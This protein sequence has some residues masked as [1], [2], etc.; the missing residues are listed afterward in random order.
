MNAVVYAGPHQMELRTVPEPVLGVGEVLVRVTATGICGSDISGFLGHSARRKPG[1]ILGHEVVG[2]LLD[3]TRV[4]VNPLITC[5]QCRACRGGRQNCCPN[6]GLL[7]LDLRHGGYADF[8]AVPARNVRPLKA[9][10]SNLQ[11]VMI[12]PLANAFHMAR[13]AIGHTGPRPSALLLG[14]GTL[15]ACT[16]AAA[17]AYGIEIG[18]VSEPSHGRR[19][20]VQS[21]GVPVGIDPT[22]EDLGAR[23]K[24]V[25]GPEGPDVVFECVGIAA[26]RQQAALNVGSGGIA[27]YLGLHSNDTTLAFLDVV[28][29]ELRL[30]GSFAFSE[31]D[32][33][34]SAE[35]VE[36]GGID[37]GPWTRYSPFAD[38]QSAFELASS[39][40]DDILKIALGPA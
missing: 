22:Q 12:E 26:T 11:A 36:G 9:S 4:V 1:L 10:T 32:F 18:A 5:G 23:V 33:L 27:I 17:K 34:A 28:R 3:G 13:T 15:G 37:F 6:W 16:V 35:Y 24:D 7:G 8:V 38:A 30:Q 29:R 25:F 21:L 19:S 20:I 2:E 40:P 39:G 14:G 31:N